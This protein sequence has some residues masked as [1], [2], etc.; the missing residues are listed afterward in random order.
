MRSSGRF[1]KKNYRGSGRGVIGVVLP[2][3]NWRAQGIRTVCNLYL[4]LTVRDSAGVCTLCCVGL[5]VV[6]S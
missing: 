1:P 6:L 4:L 5:E 2:K 3:R